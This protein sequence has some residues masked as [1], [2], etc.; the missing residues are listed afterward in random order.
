MTSICVV[1]LYTGNAVGRCVQDVECIRAKLQMLLM[2]GGKIL[3]K[4]H[5]DTF[6]TGTIDLISLSAKVCSYLRI[7]R[8]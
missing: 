6:I 3:E 8:Y 2:I 7:V 5:V 4:R 1:I